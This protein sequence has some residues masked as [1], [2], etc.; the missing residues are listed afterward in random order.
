MVSILMRPSYAK[1]KTVN[2][3]N[4][5]HNFTLRE[6]MSKHLITINWMFISAIYGCITN[7]KGQQKL[8]YQGYLCIH[9]TD[10]TNRAVVWECE[11]SCL[12]RCPAGVK[13]PW[14]RTNF[15]AKWAMDLT[16][17]CHLGYTSYQST[18]HH[19]YCCI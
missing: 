15:T 17:R 7:N 11:R 9:Q 8:L 12:E 6:S 3:L 10:L 4:S 16:Q 1:T 19:Q 18:T 5:G 2:I 13:K 14:R